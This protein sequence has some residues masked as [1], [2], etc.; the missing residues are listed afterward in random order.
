MLPGFSARHADAAA[1]YTSALLASAVLGSDYACWLACAL[2]RAATQAKTVRETD[3]VDFVL[4]ARTGR[5]ARR[6]RHVRWDSFRSTGLQSGASRR[7]NSLPLAGCGPHR[8]GSTA[9]PSATGALI[10]ASHCAAIDAMPRTGSGRH[11][12]TRSTIR[13]MGRNARGRLPG[14]LLTRQRR[15]R[16]SV[17]RQHVPAF[18]QRQRVALDGTSGPSSGW[19]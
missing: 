11:P 2:G 5:P 10:P 19:L 13:T 12:P 17:R 6:T 3:D 1:L 15:H 16:Q 4:C 14:H 18:T 9:I 7:T 8:L